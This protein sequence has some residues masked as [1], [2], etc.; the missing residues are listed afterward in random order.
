KL[1]KKKLKPCHLKFRD[2]QGRSVPILGTGNFQVTYK[3]F[4]G[5]LLVIIIDGSCLSLIGISHLI[6]SV[7]KSDMSTL[8]TEFATVF[9]DG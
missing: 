2:Y 6:N 9:E 5:R 3:K 8:I 1:S 4:A 7:T